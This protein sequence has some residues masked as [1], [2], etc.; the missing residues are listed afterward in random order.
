[1][2]ENLTY[3]KIKQRVRELEQEIEKYKQ[4]D[5]ALKESEELHRVTL[6][7]ISDAVFITDNKGA[8]T[9]IC[10]NVDVI[11]GYAYQEVQD[12]MNISKLVGD[13]LFDPN[14]L[15]TSGE[16][17]NIERRIADKAGKIHDL[18]VNVK[19]VS[20][21]GGSILLSCRDISERKQAEEELRFERDNLL[22]ILESMEDG[23]YIVD[24]GNNVKYAN[25]SL[26]KEFGAYEGKNV[27]RIFTTAMK[28]VPGA[29]M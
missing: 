6:A 13:G 18:L 4:T 17:S 25:Q 16:I 27:T 19:R 22:N 8:F 1:M 2:T 9:F 7:N 24:Q 10:P 3:Q 12:L 5:E 20:I 26:I 11:F 15:E 14:Q 28:Y 23:V 21:K 29:K